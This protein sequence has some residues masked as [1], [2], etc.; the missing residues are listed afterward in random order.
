MAL[1]FF[2][3]SVFHSVAQAAPGLEV[4]PLNAEI[5]GS[6]TMP[7]SSVI[8]FMP[9]MIACALNPSRGRQFFV[10]SSLVHIVSSRT[11]K[12]P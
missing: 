6:N 8:V 4:I 5:T 10:S 3:Q 12:A 1:I 2:R 11:A 9:G 7:D